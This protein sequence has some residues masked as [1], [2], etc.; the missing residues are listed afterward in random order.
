VAYTKRAH[1]Y[2]SRCKCGDWFDHFAKQHVW[3]S[4]ACRER[5][6]PRRTRKWPTRR[7]LSVFTCEG[8]GKGFHPPN[9]TAGRFCSR[10]CAYASFS[11]L[12][13]EKKRNIAAHYKKHL[14]SGY[15]IVACQNCR[16]MFKPKNINSTHCSRECELE[17]GRKKEWLKRR[18]QV[19]SCVACGARF[20]NLN[21][22]GRY[23]ACSELCARERDA[24][25]TK[26]M[27]SARKARERGAKSTIYLVDP[28][29]VL[30]RDEWKCRACGCDT[31]PDLRGT[32]DDNAPEIDHIWP[33]S[34]G[35]SHTY[36]NLQ[37][38][39]R[40]CNLLKADMWQSEFAQRYLGAGQDGRGAASNAAV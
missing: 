25:Q 6:R 34:K 5:H 12:M 21:G 16:K 4:S 18:G 26:K 38:L 40:L 33:L 31:P 37:T 15:R 35:G 11:W 7:L 32:N 30:Q 3:C 1:R 27:K 17:T 10:H 19:V 36:R 13:R 14:R 23:N 8:C 2:F 39:C 29:L 20:C 9:N 24:R 22:Y 28:L